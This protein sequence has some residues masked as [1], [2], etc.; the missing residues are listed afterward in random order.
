MQ[1][2]LFKFR[3]TLEMRRNTRNAIIIDPAI[4]VRFKF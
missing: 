1:R 2:Y 4:H 3:S